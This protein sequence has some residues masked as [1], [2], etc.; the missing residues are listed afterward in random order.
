[1]KVLLSSDYR[2][3]VLTN[4]VCRMGGKKI[5]RKIGRKYLKWRYH[6]CVGESTYI[7]GNLFMPHP[8]NIVI[9]N[10]VKIGRDVVIYHDVTIGVKNRTNTDIHTAYAEIE[11]GVCIYAGAKII[12][13]VK[14]REGCGVGCNSVVNCDTEAMGVY[15]GMPARNVASK[16]RKKEG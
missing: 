6:I 15:V 16:E 2:A 9:G 14:V 11:D 12:G 10:G 7:S 13:N 3:N 4:Y 1:M 8:Q 5:L